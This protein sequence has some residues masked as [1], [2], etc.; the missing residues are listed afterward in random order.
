MVNRWQVEIFERKEVG[1]RYRKPNNLSYGLLAKCKS[2]SEANSAKHVRGGCEDEE[3]FA[4][5]VG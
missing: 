3:G 4:Y 2:N 5:L 1:K